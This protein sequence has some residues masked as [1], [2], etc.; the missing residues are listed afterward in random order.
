MV[1]GKYKES[2]P[3]SDPENLSVFF[4]YIIVASKITLFLFMLKCE[5][6]Y[7]SISL[8]TLSE[9]DSILSE[10]DFTLFIRS[11]QYWEKLWQRRS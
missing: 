10:T 8:L 6:S 5:S 7:K 4:T 9:K 1:F 3:K 11:K 2:Y